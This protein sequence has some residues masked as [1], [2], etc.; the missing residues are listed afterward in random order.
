MAKIALLMPNQVMIQFAQ[1]AVQQLQADA[2]VF[3]SD[4]DHVLGTL[5]QARKEGAQVVVA[6]GNMASILRHE[7]DIPLVE[8]QISGQELI[9]A[10]HEAHGMCDQSD[11]LIALM[12]FDRMFT[13]VEPVARVLGANVKI[14]TARN[15]AEVDGLVDQALAD[16]A[17]VIVGGDL[18]LHRAEQHHMK[19]LYLNSTMP[20]IVSALN[21]AKRVLFA[22]EA[23]QRQTNE[24]SSLLN[25]TFD[26]ILKLDKE[27]TI[28]LANFMAERIFHMPKSQLVG[29]NLFDLIET[30]KDSPFTRALLE[31]RSTYS[32][33]VQIG[34]EEHVA[35]LSALGA[36]EHFVG[37]VLALQGFRHIDDMHNT[38]QKNHSQPLTIHRA[39]HELDEYNY[40]SEKMK[41][42]RKD[43]AIIAQYDLPVMIAG[44]P[45]TRRVRLAEC[46]HNA[47]SRAQKPFVHLDLSAM[48]PEMQVA[49]M[50][51][52]QDK[53]YGQ[54][55]AFQIAAEGGT[56]V[57]E[58]FECL[59]EA[60]QPLFKHI[61]TKHYILRSD[62]VPY[63]RFDG[64]I[65][66]TVNVDSQDKKWWMPS[67]PF[68]FSCF[69]LRVPS[70]SERPDDLPVLLAEYLEEFS[71]KYKKYIHVPAEIKAQA[72]MRTWAR[73]EKEFRSF[74]EKLVLLS[75]HYEADE[76]LIQRL[77][78][79]P[80]EEAGPETAP[81]VVVDSSEEALL[82][83]ALK[84]YRGSRAEIAEAMGISKTTL[85][86]KLKKYN[87]NNLH[88]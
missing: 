37:F 39:T 25:S 42:L 23:A 19:T 87:L 59:C 40:P 53:S 24:I 4:S 88:F 18:A 2:K 79:H 9:T 43:A 51:I 15:T 85:W 16:G 78:L 46:I 12:G 32:T 74:V 33:V 81:A 45:G 76:K 29:K 34:K 73:D 60:A 14:Y 41:N 30:R 72:F 31:Q 82:I 75:D 68:D 20:S 22:V 21:A 63:Y 35:S 13:E 56:I 11:D 62:G 57:L 6:R 3:F 83:A 52:P 38:L 84:K 5:A 7:T 61:L 8:I 67:L 48:S 50:V 44:A 28:L 58:H 69:E 36:G 55:N 65:I 26:A 47:S 10:L 71:V 66:F 1:E 64:R 70:L 77:V 86:R 17:K 80:T 27:G 54:Q 49:Q